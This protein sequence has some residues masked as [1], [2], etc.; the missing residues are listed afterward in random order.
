MSKCARCGARKGKRSCPALG[1]SI[2]PVCCAEERLETIPC[3]RDC[4]H[5]ASEYYQHRRRRERAFSRGRDFVTWNAK[6]FPQEIAREFAFKL[7]ADIYYYERAHGVVDDAVVADALEDLAESMGKIAFAQRAS[8]PLG[9]FLKERLTD[10]RRYKLP[11]AWSAEA[12]RDAVQALSTRVRSLETG[13]AGDHASSPKRRHSEI[14]QSFFGNLDFEADLDYS[15]ED[16]PEAPGTR[17]EDEGHERHERPGD[18]PRS[19]G[20]IITP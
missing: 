8:S 14:L 19:A 18:L 1:A 3:P 7:Q 13:G 11:E 15:P 16:G 4:P 9:T 12:R 2:C 5:L 6:H 20:G 17:R 10:E